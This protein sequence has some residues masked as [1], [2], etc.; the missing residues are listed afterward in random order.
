MMSDLVISRG[1]GHGSLN[2]AFS[3]FIAQFPLQQKKNKE[4][5]EIKNLL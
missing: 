1:S 2:R 3:S 5:K 4:E